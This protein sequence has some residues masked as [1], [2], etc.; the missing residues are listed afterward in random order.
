M[1]SVDFEIL[2]PDE[3]WKTTFDK[4]N[5]TTGTYEGEKYL[6]LSCL[7]YTSPSPRDR[8]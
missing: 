1:I 5:K 6:V 2:L 8:G 7:L 4:G 3:P